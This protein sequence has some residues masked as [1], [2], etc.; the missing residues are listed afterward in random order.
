[1][2]LVLLQRRDAP[3]AVTLIALPQFGGS[4]LGGTAAQVLLLQAPLLPHYRVGVQKYL[5]I[6]MGKDFCSNVAPFHHHS[7]FGAH[8]LLAGNHPRPDLGMDRDPRSSLG[9]I[10][11]ADTRG[12]VG[13]IEQNPIAS[14]SRL[15]LDTRILGQL[16]QSR[17]VVEGNV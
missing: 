8:F 16:R 7:A 1:M 12:Y 14:R 13:S 2:H 17:L 10:G 15:Q 11:F 4:R 3:G 6:C 5:H 9:H